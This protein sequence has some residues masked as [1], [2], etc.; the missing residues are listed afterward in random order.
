MSLSKMLIIGTGVFMGM[1]AAGAFF[2]IA[3]DYNPLL[4][5]TT[6]CRSPSDGWIRC[7]ND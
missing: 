3:D 6:F 4:M 7:D 2:G 1:L 5:E